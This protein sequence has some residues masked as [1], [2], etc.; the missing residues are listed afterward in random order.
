MSKKKSK[1]ALPDD[2]E[3]LAELAT[4]DEAGARIPTSREVD[5]GQVP[6]WCE[7]VL[8]V[9]RD[10]R[11]EDRPIHTGDM[12]LRRH[13]GELIIEVLDQVLRPNHS[14]SYTD[15]IWSALDDAVERIQR[16]VAKGKAPR[17]DDVGE[18]RG[19]AIA[20]AAMTNPREPN[21]DEVREVAMTR[22]DIRHG[23]SR[24]D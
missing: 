4:L 22:F 12:Y 23:I 15:Q 17:P 7:L 21:V 9:R 1:H 6:P 19:L 3:L 2:A 10:G 14:M 18:A 5:A 11:I 16:R 20:L 24:G 8:H 13:D